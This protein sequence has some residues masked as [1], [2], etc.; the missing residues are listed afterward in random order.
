ML[1]RRIALTLLL[2]FGTCT[3][4]PQPEDFH[5]IESLMAHYGVPG[6]GV[7]V[8][9]ADGITLESYGVRQAGSSDLVTPATL[10]QAASISKSVTAMAV[11][12]LVQEKRLRLNTPINGSLTTWKIPDNQFTEAQPVT[13]EHL[14]S[15]TGGTTVSGFRGYGP[16]ETVP[17]LVQVLNGVPPANSAPIVVDKLPG[18]SYRYSGGG[19]C[20]IEQCL[21]DVTGRHLHEFVAARVLTPLQMTDSTFAQPLPDVLQLR[22]SSGHRH[23]SKKVVELYHTYPERAA[24]GLWATPRDLARFAVGL[25][26]SLAG[27]RGAVLTKPTATRMVAPVTPSYA[28]GVVP[29]LHNGEPYFSHSGHNEGF[30]SFLIAH[31]TAGVGAVIMINKENTPVLARIVQLL[32][33]RES[34]PGFG[35]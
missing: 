22:A 15:H 20:V 28:L 35:G 6:V 29:V 14:L 12:T 4:G 17:T 3:S 11:M 24:A 23:N 25:Q 30:E 9:R 7:A 32:A 2:A 16:G 5:D 31:Q 33:E 34:W 19:Y 8:I 10:F 1:A 27:A 21:A 18:E 26:R 13:L